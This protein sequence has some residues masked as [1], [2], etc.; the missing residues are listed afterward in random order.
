MKLLLTALSFGLIFF[1]SGVS[2]QSTPEISLTKI[3]SVD[4]KI[5]ITFESSERFIIGDNR[6]VL[7]AGGN[8]FMLSKH[9]GG[10]EKKLTFLL[11]EE[12]YDVLAD[13][14]PMMLV[15]GYFFQNTQLDG[16][17]DS[18][19]YHGPHWKVGNLNKGLLQK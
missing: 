6:Y 11:T 18:G 12:E 8:H 13:G 9:P 3:E 5:E 4:D 16:E 19:E 2:A 14:S 1:S 17:G 10:D 15:Y 7:H